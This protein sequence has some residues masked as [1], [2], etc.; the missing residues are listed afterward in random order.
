MQR[1][2]KIFFLV[3][4]SFFL[5]T[6]ADAEKIGLLPFSTTGI[7]KNITTGIY[8]IIQSELSFYGHTVVL[9]EEIEEDLGKKIECDNKKCAVEIGTQ[10]EL[11]KVILGYLNKLGR[12]YIISVLVVESQ[13]GK[14]VFSG[15]FDSN[16]AEDLYESISNIAKSIGNGE[17]TK[18]L[19]EYEKKKKVY[20][21]VGL[22]WGSAITLKGYADEQIANHA[23]AAKF[24]LETQR[25]AAA[26]DWDM[27]ESL[28][29]YDNYDELISLSFLYF[30]TTSDFAPFISVGVGWEIFTTGT[31][32]DLTGYAYYD[33]DE[34]TAFELGG[35]LV[36]FRTYHVRFVLDAKLST[37]FKEIGGA[38]G[39]HSAL[40]LGFS[41]LYK[42]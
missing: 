2:K 20:F 29:G 13:T 6:R 19:E 39:P 7:E 9:P 37:S 36:M 41:A 35:G 3:I 30:F 5:S 32:E 34:S 22:E 24:W 38:E 14:T 25:F 16:N 40:R 12:K 4:F 18:D 17:S 10:I 27:Y 42:F 1:L 11:E 21:S 26:L 33:Y 15:K 28:M 31:H 8:H 23:A